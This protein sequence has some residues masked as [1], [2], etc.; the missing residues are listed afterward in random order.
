MAIK[1]GESSDYNPRKAE[2]VT[3]GKLKVYIHHST[4]LAFAVLY[5]IGHGGNGADYS[6]AWNTFWC[7]DGVWEPCSDTQVVSPE[8][9]QQIIDEA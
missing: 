5:N 8:Q 9:L 6:D 2:I 7:L 4:G 1:V 3:L